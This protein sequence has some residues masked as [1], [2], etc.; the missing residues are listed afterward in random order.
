[1]NYINM[2]TGNKCR[3]SGYAEILIEADL[4]TSGCLE[5]VLRGRAYAKALF[6]LKTVCKGME[7]LLIERFSEEENLAISS[8]IALMRLQNLINHENLNTVLDDVSTTSLLDRYID[9]EDKVHDGYL[10]KS[11][12]F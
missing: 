11:A 2:L 3:G 1:M 5:S 8:P 4:V 10:G 7:R 12:T 9:F 6:C